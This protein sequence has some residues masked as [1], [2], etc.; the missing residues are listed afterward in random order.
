MINLF[1][2]FTLMVTNLIP[3]LVFAQEFSSAG[4]QINTLR[5]IKEQIENLDTSIQTLQTYVD[6]VVAC[7]DETPPKHYNGTACV[8]INERDPN[9]ETH[10]TKALSAGSCSASNE[11]QQFNGSSWGCKTFN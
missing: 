5:Q 2:A 6:N 11:A 3:S 4:T 1:L 10:G 8:T 7:G 9:I